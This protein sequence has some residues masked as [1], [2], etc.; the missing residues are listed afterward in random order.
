MKKFILVFLTLTMLVGCSQEKGENKPV[1]K[2]PAPQVNENA[3][4]SS[5][6]FEK[7]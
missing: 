7:H 3:E 4:S 5:K 1:P 2:D 6:A